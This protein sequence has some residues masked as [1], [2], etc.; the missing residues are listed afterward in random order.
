MTPIDPGL[1]GEIEAATRELRRRGCPS[2]GGTPKLWFTED[3]VKIA[4]GIVKRVDSWFAGLGP[5]F[6]SPGFQDEIM[7]IR[8]AMGDLVALVG[9]WPFGVVPYYVPR[10]RREITVQASLVERM[11]HVAAGQAFP[12]EYREPDGAKAKVW[13]PAVMVRRR[14]T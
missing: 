4:G 12:G 10:R 3:L 14:G 7:S 11:A 2:P 5:R 8:L 1:T 9:A 6:Q 13:M